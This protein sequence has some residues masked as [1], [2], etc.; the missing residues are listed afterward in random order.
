MQGICEANLR[1]QALGRTSFSPRFPLVSATYPP[2]GRRKPPPVRRLADSVGRADACAPIS[3]RKHAYMRLF[4]QQPLGSVPSDGRHRLRRLGST[5]ITF[6]AQQKLLWCA[7]EDKMVRSKSCFG[8]QQRTKWCAAKVALVRSRGQNGAHQKLLWCAAEDKMVRT[9]SCFGAQQRTKW[10]APK[11]ASVRSKV[12][13]QKSVS[14][15][16]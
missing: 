6:G 4:G 16:F 14:N 5:N 1:G 8:A 7:A 12:S 2:R 15:W 9:K 11:V 10:C 13:T 3:V